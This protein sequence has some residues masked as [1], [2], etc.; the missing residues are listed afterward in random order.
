[1]EE[2]ELIEMYEAI[3]SKVDNIEKRLDHLIVK[4]NTQ[5]YLSTDIKNV[6][7]KKD[8]DLDKV[9]SDITDMKKDITYMMGKFYNKISYLESF[10]EKQNKIFADRDKK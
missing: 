1:M 10:I 3:F 8:M 9:I 5:E 4:S 6:L 7:D 2:K